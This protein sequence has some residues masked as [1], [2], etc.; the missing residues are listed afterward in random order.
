MSSVTLRAVR[1]DE[2]PQLAEL[3]AELDDELPLP[4]NTLAAILHRMQAFPDYTCYFAER[5]GDIVGT[6]SLLVFP[7]L[8]SRLASE[9][10]VESVV[11]RRAL[12]GQ[13]VGEAMMGAAIRLAAARGAYKLCLSS[14][15]RRQ[16]AHRFYDRIGFA[17]HGYSFAI[18][19]TATHD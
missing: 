4:T 14:N 10:I 17:R 7:V 5:A 12:R 9:A 8:S 15:L 18:D 16:D 6:L 13:G 3:L 11:V 2:L 19:T 1:E